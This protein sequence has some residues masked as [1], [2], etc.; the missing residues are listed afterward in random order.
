[1]TLREMLSISQETLKRLKSVEGTSPRLKRLLIREIKDDI[2]YLKEN[3][4][5]EKIRRKRR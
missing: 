3:E 2:N 5:Y 4:G 1:M